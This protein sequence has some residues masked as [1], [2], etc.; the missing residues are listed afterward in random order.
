MENIHSL[1]KRQLKKLLG[2]S[3]SLPK[4]LQ[5]IFKAINNAYIQSDIDRN[6][7]ERSLD[8]SSEELF[9]ANAEFR[10][11]LSLLNATIESTRDGIL[12]VDL[13]GTIA[14]FNKNFVD[15]WHIPQYIIDSRDDSAALSFVLEQLQDPDGFIKRIQELNA[16]TDAESYD[17]LQFK[18]GRIFERYSRPQRIEEKYV[19]RVW[20]FHD[21]TIQKEAEERLLIKSQAIESSINAIAFLD[22]DA[23]LTYA[24]ESFLRLWGYTNQTEVVG[25]SALDFWHQKENALKVIELLLQNGQGSWFGELTARRKDGSLFDA[26]LSTNLVRKK[27]GTPICLLGSF[28]DITKRKLAEQALKIKDIDLEIKTKNLEEINT[29]L[30]VLLK[31]R[32][33]DKTELEEKVLSNIKQ[34]I[35]PYI[36]KL[37]Q[38]GLNEMQ[39]ALTAILESN[40]KDVTSSFSYSLSSIHLNLTPSEVKI[41]NLITQ[42]KTSKEICEILGSSQKMVAFHRQ[43][44]RRKLGLQNKKVNL[45]SYLIAKALK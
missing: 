8:L 37:K 26:Q 20:S 45:K 22:L 28:I 44:I 1:L 29:A 33:E 30:N 14:S 36:S 5:E 10:K 19:G 24:N 11:T 18:D 35:E 23:K 39:K 43:N 12:V 42:D 31:K 32:E 27:K 2:N 7:L 4:E 40:L 34:L 9:T 17:L 15:M 13:N 41:A 16:Q 21:I 6:M 38:S 3:Y 25:R